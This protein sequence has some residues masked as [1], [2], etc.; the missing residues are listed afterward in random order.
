[1]GKI[2]PLMLLPPLLFLGLAVMFYIGNFREGRNDLPSARAGQEAPALGVQQLGERTLLTDAMLREGEVT[3]VNFWATWCPPCRAEHPFLEELAQGRHDHLR[4][5]LPRS[6]PIRR[7]ISWRNWATPSP[8]SG[9]TP[10]RARVWIGASWACRKP[11]W[12][13]VMAPSNSAMP[14]PSRV[15]SWK[16]VSAPRWNARRRADPRRI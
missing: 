4:R 11:L 3:L 13:Q 2:R 8:P 14:G 16:I 15:R 1:M 5:E 12:L 7:K 10:L 6:G 9:R